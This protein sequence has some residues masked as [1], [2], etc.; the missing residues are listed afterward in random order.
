MGWRRCAGGAAQQED[1][2]EKRKDTWRKECLVKLTVVWDFVGFVLGR[3][4]LAF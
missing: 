3:L 2:E 1:D 4:L